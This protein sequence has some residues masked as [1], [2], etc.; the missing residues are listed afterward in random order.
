MREISLHETVLSSDML[1]KLPISETHSDRICISPWT[2]RPFHCV[3][4]KPNPSGFWFSW[5]EHP[6]LNLFVTYI[7]WTSN[8]VDGRYPIFET[9]NLSTEAKVAHIL[10]SSKRCTPTRKMNLLGTCFDDPAGSFKKVQKLCSRGTCSVYKPLFVSYRQHTLCFR[11]LDSELKFLYWNPSISFMV[12]GL[13]ILLL[14]SSLCLS[15]ALI[16]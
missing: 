2:E 14:V 6:G 4:I 3:F 1:A 7:C 12:Q 8:Q 13:D 9:T 5:N 11:F 10:N 15:F 16:D